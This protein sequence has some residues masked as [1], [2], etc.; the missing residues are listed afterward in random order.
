MISV[1]RIA[2]KSSD[3]RLRPPSY[4]KINF[5]ECRCV[6]EDKPYY[7]FEISYKMFDAIR[8]KERE[9][10]KMYNIENL[11]KVKSDVSFGIETPTLRLFIKEFFDYVH[12]GDYY[13]FTCEARF[14]KTTLTFWYELV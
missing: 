12:Y 3:P 13:N 1:H 9:I 8:A 4:G 2:F 6:I 14:N 11:W 7:T 5:E 10:A